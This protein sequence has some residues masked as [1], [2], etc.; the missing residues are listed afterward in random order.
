[1]EQGT[2]VCSNKVEQTSVPCSSSRERVEGGHHLVVGTEARKAQIGEV[3]LEV[4]QV[5]TKVF[6]RMGVRAEREDGATQ[7]AIEL[8]NLASGLRSCE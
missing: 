2:E 8:Q 6:G 4:A 5:G 1:M 3:A 7:V